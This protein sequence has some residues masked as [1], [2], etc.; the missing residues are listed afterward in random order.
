MAEVE[1][2]TMTNQT[3]AN[4]LRRAPRMLGLLTA[5]AL[6]AGLLMAQASP[7][8]AARQMG[9]QVDLGR[10]RNAPG[11]DSDDGDHGQERRHQHRIRR[12]QGRRPSAAGRQRRQSV[13][14]GGLDLLRDDDAHL[15]GSARS[16]AMGRYRRI[17]WECH[18]PNPVHRCGRS[19][20]VWCP[21]Q[22]WRSSP[23]AERKTPTS[24]RS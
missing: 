7:A 15:H 12:D 1:T 5:L 21:Q 6:L 3:N 9:H 10:N 18:Q 8:S 20:R 14:R 24:T 13:R 4:P 2:M 22:C 17:A 11:H 23:A 16:Q 19:R